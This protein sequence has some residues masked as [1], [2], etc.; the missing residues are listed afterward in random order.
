[1]K[2]LITACAVSLLMTTAAFADGVPKEPKTVKP[3]SHLFF[4]VKKVIV[5]VSPNSEMYPSVHKDFTKSSNDCNCSDTETSENSLPK[6]STVMI[7]N[8]RYT[9]TLPVNKK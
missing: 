5:K 9:M 3:I 2:K 8:L 7:H 1:M 4:N 6:R